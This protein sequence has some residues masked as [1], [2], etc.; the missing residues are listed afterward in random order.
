MG[1]KRQGGTPGV[2]FS[3]PN[4]PQATQISKFHVG[5]DSMGRELRNTS[6]GGPSSPSA[7]F[8]SRLSRARAHSH[9]VM[10]VVVTHVHISGLR[11]PINMTYPE[12]Y[13]PRAF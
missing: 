3:G 9:L 2:S 5:N 6:R 1:A 10:N 11:V 13:T 4:P 12:A 7:R 8:G